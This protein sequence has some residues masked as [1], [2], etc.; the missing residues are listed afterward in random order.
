M[1][2]LNKDAGVA[3]ADEVYWQPM[4]TCP[5]NIKVQLYTKGKVAVYGMIKYHFENSN[6]QFWAPLPR[7]PEE[8]HHEP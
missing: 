3:V 6:Y 7:V 8:V 5:K 1:F 4:L 2:H